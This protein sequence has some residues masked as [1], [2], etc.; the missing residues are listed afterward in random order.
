NV[1]GEIRGREKPDEVVV[2]G[3][4]IDSWD[5]G[6]GAHDDGAG[7]V[8]MMHALTTIRKLGLQPR[9]TIRVVCFTNE[10]NGLAGARGGPAQHAGEL[11]R[12]VAAMES[13]S[14][15]FAPIGV[16]A[17]IGD[18]QGDAARAILGDIMTLLEPIH[19][20]RLE[21]GGSGA[22]VSPMVAPGGV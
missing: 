22:D 5:V 20:T 10:E 21:L 19:A 18:A 12:T 7:I 1:I 2:I 8:T 4:H 14:G 16:S 17:N 6:Q 13:A 9:R 3:G 11:A 15:G